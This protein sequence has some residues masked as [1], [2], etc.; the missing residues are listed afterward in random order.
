MVIFVTIL[1]VV[2]GPGVRV[3]VVVRRSRSVVVLGRPVGGPPVVIVIPVGLSVRIVGAGGPVIGAG[4]S[5][6]GSWRPVISARGAVMMDGLR[7]VWAR[8]TVIIIA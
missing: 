5:V 4:W 2:N 7:V 1:V 8:R 6:V 3:L